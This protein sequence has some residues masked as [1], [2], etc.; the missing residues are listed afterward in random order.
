ME[1]KK[2]LAQLSQL[3]EEMHQYERQQNGR[4]W[5]IEEETL[6]YLADAGTIGTEI[7]AQ[8]K[9][10]PEEVYDKDNL[11]YHLAKNIWWLATIAKH[12]DI[13]LEKELQK[14]LVGTL[15]PSK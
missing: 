14:L 2:Y 3:D 6:T 7:M 8:S 5:T 13:D 1:L 15:D 4:Q 9:S 10:L 12:Q 11:G